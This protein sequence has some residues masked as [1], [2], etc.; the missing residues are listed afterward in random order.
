MNEITKKLEHAQPIVTLTETGAKAEGM[1]HVD[2]PSL[3]SQPLSIGSHTGESFSWTPTELLYKDG[4]Q[5]DYIVGSSPST[6][7]IR[8]NQ[9]KYSRTFP[10]AD[11][12]FHLEGDRVKHWLILNEAPRTKAEYLTGT[13]YFGVSGIISGVPLPPGEHE[14]INIEVF[15]LP[16]PVIKDLSGREIEGFY[17]VLDS[18][19]GQQLFIWFD[20]SFLDSAVYPVMVDPTVIVNSGYSTAGNG[21]RKIVELSNGWVV[22]A[23]WDPINYYIRLY[24]SKDKGTT[25]TE[26]TNMNLGGNNAKG[27]ALASLNNVVYTIHSNS[28][29]YVYYR[30]YDAESNSLSSSITVDASQSSMGSISLVLNGTELHGVWTSKN[31][32]YPDA[33][34]VR[35]AK[36][37]RSIDGTISWSSVEQVTTFSSFDPNEKSVSVAVVNNIPAVFYDGGNSVTCVRKVN[38]SWAY[39]TINHVAGY[40]QLNPSAVIDKN[41]V[42]HVVWHGLD[43]TDT[44]YYNIRYA[45]STD[46]GS[47]WS[48]AVKL[49]IGNTMHCQ[50]PSITCDK[51][52]KLYITYEEN[53]VI[54]RIESTDIGESWS[55]PVTVEIGTNPNMAFDPSYS[56]NLVPWV[57]MS[58]STV[59]L[60]KIELNQPPNAPT[61]TPKSNFDAIKAADFY[62]THNDPDPSDGQS[63]YQM[64]VVD[65]GSTVLD[66]GKVASTQSKHTIPANTLANGKS[67]QWRVK[68]W[69]NADTEGVYSNYGTFSTSGTPTVSITSPTEAQVLTDSSVTV[70]WSFSSPSSEGQSAYQVELLSS[71]DAVLWNSGKVASTSA[72]SRTV[73]YTLVN[74]TSY[75]VRVTVWDTKDIPSAPVTRTISVSFVA[76]AIPSVT[77]STNPTRSSIT[78]SI[79]HPVPV[80]PEPSVVSSDVFK[81]KQGETT[82]KRIKTGTQGSFTDYTPGHN[83]VYEY[84]VRAIG[85]NGTYS[86][87]AVITSSVPVKN[88]FLEKVSDPNT[89]VQLMFNPGRSEKQGRDRTLSYFAGRKDPVPEFG[90]QRTYG[91]DASFVIFEIAELNVL[92]DLVDSGETLLYRDSRGRREYVSIADINITDQKPNY[93]E[94]SLPIRKVSYEEGV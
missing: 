65:N 55:A 54:K 42:I 4:S 53:G 58:G 23:V 82:W 11:D 43:G 83:V 48:T 86:E 40:F 14:E 72:R 91:L 80:D 7:A 25:F 47:T 63:A 73:D 52:N 93:Y 20:S 26:A 38:G 12:V 57:Y 21:G 77:V 39:S 81:R 74:S 35:Y 85:T 92:R 78:L 64:Q 90:Q 36:G 33:F 29:G 18:G 71:A 44:T 50:K 51:N 67:Y 76:P 75:K 61:L 6:L 1:Y 15:K 34:N 60:E 9:V 28:N 87:S 70:Q 56:S 89:F 69:D 31:T 94:V 30:E 49:T 13:V 66:T 62:W 88:A 8:G 24:V 3:A 59:K 45:K 27:L 17:E 68:T 16:K 19:Q 22:A 37:I 5:L 10:D 32:S 46:Q 2:I 84:K 79:T 41:G